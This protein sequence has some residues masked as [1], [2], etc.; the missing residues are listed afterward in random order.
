MFRRHLLSVLIACVALIVFG[1]VALSVMVSRS[2]EIEDARADLRAMVAVMIEHADRAIE[3]GDKLIRAVQ[4][5]M[6]AWDLTDKDEAQELMRRMRALLAGSPQLSAAWIVKPDGTKVLD[7][8]DYPP[9]SPG[10]IEQFYLRSHREGVPEPVIAGREAGPMSGK[11]RFTISRSVR[12]P[13]GSLHAILVVGILSDY[14]TALHSQVFRQPDSRAG[15]FLTTGVTSAEVLARMGNPSPASRTFL[16][17]LYSRI[18]RE[19][20]GVAVIDGRLSAWH[21]S[22]TFPTVFAS[23]SMPMSAINHWKTMAWQLGLLAALVVAVFGFVV[24]LVSKYNRAASKNH[25][26]QLLLAELNHRM[27]NNLQ[28]LQGAL[29]FHAGSAGEAGKEVLAKVS[30]TLRAVAEIFSIQ[31]RHPDK[32]QVDFCEVL[33]AL[34][35]TI[36]S[37]THR[38]IDLRS[39]GP[40]PMS[41]K[42]AT[43]LAI[44]LNELLTNAL[45]YSEGPVVVNCEAL[46]SPSIRVQS[47]GALK[48]GADGNGF[49]SRMIGR[50]LSTLGGTVS[51]EQADGSYTV[52]IRFPK[53]FEG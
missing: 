48:N 34:C 39:Q 29:S 6:L 1:L 16:N 19:P 46:P 4:D 36:R 28:V 23:A 8:W 49:G 7:T 11:L 13:D 21:R 33:T 15:L 51:A 24:V 31:Q 22:P 37:T 44:V 53:G 2:N 12:K 42:S 30:G 18:D 40:L 17:N 27:K 35:D 52:T 5:R 26:D 3:D 20:V 32:D 10:P 47:A 43:D 9:R 41:G 25:Y 50:V 38:V 45:K 14:F